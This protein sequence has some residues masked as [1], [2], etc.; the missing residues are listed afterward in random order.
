MFYKFFQKLEPFL[1]RTYKRLTNPPIPNLKGDRDIEYSFVSANLP[2]GPG[3][4]LDFGCGLSW[5][6]LLAARKGFKVT[7]IDLEP[8]KWFYRHPNLKFVQGD[9]FELNF[10]SKYFDLIINCSS[11]EH[12]GLVGRYGV[13]ENREDGDLEAMK[14]LKDILKPEGLMF[15]TIPVGKDTVFYPLHRIYGEERLPK[16]LEG[17][18]IMKEEFWMKNSDNRWESVKKETALNEKPK[19]HC[20]N[21][22]LFVLQKPK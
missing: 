22:G 12:V 20:Y 13:K 15:L 9:I 21:L 7:A 5:I 6:G 18:E 17:W 14:I 2:E 10:P 8:I 19:E 4:A 11:I 16:L 1:L 3:E